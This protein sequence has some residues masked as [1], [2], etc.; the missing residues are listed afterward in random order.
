MTF[1]SVLYFLL[2]QFNISHT[3]NL[4]VSN[5]VQKNS[6]LLNITYRIRMRFIKEQKWRNSYVQYSPC[7]NLVD[8]VISVILVKIYVKTSANNQWV[9]E[10]NLPFH[11][12]DRMP[13]D[14]AFVSF[15]DLL[16]L[17]CVFRRAAALFYKVMIL[18]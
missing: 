4:S 14:F 10:I 8:W 11:C 1:I 12:M 7:I 6:N 15:H 18:F 16:L 9:T 13:S 5:K 3:M 2:Q 17:F